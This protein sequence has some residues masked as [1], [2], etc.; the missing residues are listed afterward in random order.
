MAWRFVVVAAA[1]GL[2]PPATA[3]GS[4][5]AFIGCELSLE[6]ALDEPLPTDGVIPF[7]FQTGAAFSDLAIDVEIRDDL[8]APIDGELILD[9]ALAWEDPSIRIYPGLFG[10]VWWQPAEPLDSSR[11]YTVW[12]SC[13]EAAA[14]LDDAR[15]NASFQF[16]V[17]PDPTPLP[18]TPVSAVVNSVGFARGGDLRR[19]C[20]L[21]ECCSRI[22]CLGCNYASPRYF[23]SF[24][25]AVE[26]ATAGELTGQ[27]VVVARHRGEEMGRLHLQT[28]T[29]IVGQVALDS[30]EPGPWCITLETV[31]LRDGR[32]SE[33][34]EVC[35]GEGMTLPKVDYDV[36]LPCEDEACSATG[37]A[38]SSP[39][40]PLLWLL[41]GAV[42]L[43]ALRRRWTR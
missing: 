41:L 19:C 33:T 4:S 18:A 26:L 9:Y 14:R 40:N 29:S 12:T 3:L 36:D 37:A 20:R 32:S 43:L 16:A 24:E 22:S 6:P 38:P 28:G 34:I 13:R 2:M 1:I 31:R 30:L 5:C 11:Q 27:Y 35:A 7:T 8:G 23:P 25:V 42:P 21:K 15:V 10:F 39:K 17:D